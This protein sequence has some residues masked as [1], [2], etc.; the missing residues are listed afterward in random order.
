VLIPPVP[1]PAYPPE[2]DE[3]APPYIP[4]FV[5]PGIVIPPPTTVVPPGPPPCDPKIDPECPP[6][7]PPPVDVPEPAAWMVLL[8][9]ILG[10]WLAFGRYAPSRND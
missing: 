9:A 5:V 7:P 10:T 4:P 8:V 6:P 2:V 3:W 1:T